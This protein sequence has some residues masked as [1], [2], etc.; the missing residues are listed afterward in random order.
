[1]TM[2][3]RQRDVIRT[4]FA[5]VAK[6]GDGAGQAF[7]DRLFRNAPQ[8]RPMFPDEMSGQSGKLVMALKA[9]V[10]NIGD[11]PRLGAVVDELARR[12]VAYGVLPA[13]YPIVGLTLLETLGDALGED[14]TPETRD[15]W[16]AAYGALADRMIAAAYPDAA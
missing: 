14:F 12:H 1:M 7:Y 11:W 8:V 16:A 3:D 13:H 15:A 10:D 6:L 2:T 4:S 9:V 5:K